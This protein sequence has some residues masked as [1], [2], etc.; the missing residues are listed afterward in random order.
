M[1]LALF[2]DCFL[3]QKLQGYVVISRKMVIK[4]NYLNNKLNRIGYLDTYFKNI[5]FKLIE[6]THRYCYFGFKLTNIKI[7]FRDFQQSRMTNELAQ[8][9]IFCFKRQKRVEHFHFQT[10]R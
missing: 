1:A 8:N 10:F 4:Y 3:K 9:A 5:I 2:K 6:I 7:S